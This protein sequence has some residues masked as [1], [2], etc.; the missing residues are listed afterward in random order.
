MA[1]CKE[2]ATTAKETNVI[3]IKTIKQILINDMKKGAEN[4]SAPIFL[5]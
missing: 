4:A 1:S 3:R 2:V 5:D